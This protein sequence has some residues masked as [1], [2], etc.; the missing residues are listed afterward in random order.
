MKKVLI[1]GFGF[2]G[3]HI[4]EE[5]NSRGI[6][7]VVFDRY[8]H[9]AKYLEPAAPYDFILGDI[10][11]RNAVSEA[12]GMCDGAINLAGILGTSETVDNPF[13][14]LKSMSLEDSTS[15]RLADNIRNEVS[16]L[17]WVIIL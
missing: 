16:R 17:R 10:R 11:D 5:L 3:S 15:W 9:H 12:V 8:R 4:V 14:Q 2:I 13:P 1:T 7:A 6:Q